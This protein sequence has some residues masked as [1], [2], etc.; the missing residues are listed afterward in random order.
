MFQVYR[1]FEKEVLGARS[2]ETARSLN[3]AMMDFDT[4]VQQH[5]SEIQTAMKA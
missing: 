5:K 2:P 1:D 4:F 3:P